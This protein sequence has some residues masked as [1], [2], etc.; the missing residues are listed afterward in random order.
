MQPE[1]LLPE[2]TVTLSI[3]LLGGV[4][5]KIAGQQIDIGKAKAL[6][7]LTLIAMSARFRLTR[8]TLRGILWADVAEADAQNSL[9]NT[10]SILR[11]TLRAHGFDGLSSSR[12][13][14]WLDPDSFTVDLQNALDVMETGAAPASLHPNNG[15][16]NLIADGEYVSDLFADRVNSYRTAALTKAVAAGNA[17]VSTCAPDQKIALLE[18]LVA[19]QPSNEAANRA[20]IQSLIQAGRKADALASYQRLWTYLDEEFGEEPSDDTQ[21][22]IV[23]LKQPSQG[24]RPASDGKATLLVQAVDTN[25]ADGINLARLRD[26]ALANLVRFREWRIIDG[27]FPLQLQNNTDDFLCGLKFSGLET[28]DGGI[29]IHAILTDLHTGQLLWS[30]KLRLARVIMIRRLNMPSVS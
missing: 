28:S 3:E 22:L 11:K 6:A 20:Y 24:A 8:P 21:A 29:S 9:R 30:E 23:A 15:F 19:W 4:Q 17:A 10:L 14:I 5:V 18:L 13:E 27:S 7:M 2:R 16:P 12:S 25:T 1:T 26:I